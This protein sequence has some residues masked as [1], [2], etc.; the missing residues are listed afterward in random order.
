MY[1]V[2]KSLLNIYGGTKQYVEVESKIRVQ[3]L[4]EMQNKRY[5]TVVTK[6][7]LSNVLN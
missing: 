1:S 7:D 2:E 3:S 5:T 4:T 6:Y